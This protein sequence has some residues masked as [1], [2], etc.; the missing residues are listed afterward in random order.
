ME[1][2]DN[3]IMSRIAFERMQ[4]K[5]EKDN[6]WKNIIIII[7]I[8]LLALSNAMWLWYESQFEIVA[9]EISVDSGEGGNAF[10]IGNDGDI[11]NGTG[12]T[13]NSNEAQG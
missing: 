9:D 6:R 12:E 2:N 1:N 4:A 7:L 10:Y 11:N 8:A 13:Q 3:I 5:E